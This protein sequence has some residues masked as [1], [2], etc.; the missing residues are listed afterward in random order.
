MCYLT[1][2]HM[3]LLLSNIFTVAKV[4]DI[5]EASVSSGHHYINVRDED[6]GYIVSHQSFGNADYGP[7]RNWKLSLTELRSNEVEL[8]FEEISL[9]QQC[10]WYFGCYCYDYLRTPTHLKIC[11]TRTRT[12]VEKRLPSMSITFNFITNSDNSRKGFWI[13]YTGKPVL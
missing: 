3:W 8:V 10:V 5:G 6:Y 2:M 13:Q 9:E 1:H 7:N 4:I 11:G 12:I